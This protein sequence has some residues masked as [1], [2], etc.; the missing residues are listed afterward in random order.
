[1]QLSAPDGQEQL[2][3]GEYTR[4]RKARLAQKPVHR[5]VLSVRGAYR[6]AHKRSLGLGGAG[7]QMQGHVTR[8]REWALV[9]PGCRPLTPVGLPVAR[10]SA[11]CGLASPPPGFRCNPNARRGMHSAVGGKDTQRRIPQRDSKGCNFKLLD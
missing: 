7:P 10:R 9:R 3:N 6:L 4:P 5:R 8:G 11:P 2:K 1:M